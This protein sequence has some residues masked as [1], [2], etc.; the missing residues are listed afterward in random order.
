MFQKQFKSESEK[1]YQLKAIVTCYWSIKK[2][3]VFFSEILTV[4][5]T[6]VYIQK[7]KRFYQPVIKGYGMM[8]QVQLRNPGSLQPP[9]NEYFFNFSVI[10]I[11]LKTDLI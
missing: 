11:M 1:V 3:R 4:Q 7:K 8:F 9:L 10:I 5:L 6:G 2:L